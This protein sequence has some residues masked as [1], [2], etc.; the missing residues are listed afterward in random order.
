MALNSLARTRVN[1]MSRETGTEL[2]DRH[3]DVLEYAW[4]FYRKNSVGP[5]NQNIARH[6]GVSKAELADIFPHGLN[7]VLYLGGNTDPK[8]RRWM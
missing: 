2:T 5:L 6:T 1:Y 3:L 8:Q 4:R 7:S